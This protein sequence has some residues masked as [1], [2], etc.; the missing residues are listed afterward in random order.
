MP[1]F[2]MG[3]RRC[4]SQALT[5]SRF[6]AFRRGVP[7]SFQAGDVHSIG[8][9]AFNNDIRRKHSYRHPTPKTLY[10][11]FK[12]SDNSSI[13]NSPPSGRFMHQSPAQADMTMKSDKPLHIPVMLEDVLEYLHPQERQ[14]SSNTC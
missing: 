4:C 8:A 11:G 9:N 5:Y 3:C 6:S 1:V 7:I 10:D 12:N 14:V 13:Y 2:T